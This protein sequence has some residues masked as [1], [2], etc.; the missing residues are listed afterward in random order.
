MKRLI[1]LM[2]AL[3]MVLLP[4]CS[5]N[6]PE[7]TVSEEQLWKDTMTALPKDKTYSILFIG[8]SY[9]YTNDMPNAYF[10][11]MAKDAGYQLEFDTVT[12][13]AHKLIEFANSKDEYGKIVHKL[14]SEPNQY[15][16][17]ILQEQSVLPAGENAALF[18]E[19]VR[20]LA[21]MVR[22]A[23]AEPILFATW[24]RKTGS[25]TLEKYGWDHETMAWRLAAAYHAIGE[26]LNIPVVHVGLGFLNINQN[27]Q[28]INLYNL[29]MT[30]PSRSGSYL[31]AACLFAGI[32][33]VDPVTI[34]FAGPLS[35]E[36]VTVLRT[37]ARS[38]VLMPPEIP[39]GFKTSSQS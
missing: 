25:E 19:G 8:N 1:S 38:A 35:E 3:L 18:Y 22:D 36:V 7:E 24:G 30:H 39:D 12:K 14:L 13:G 2:L 29:D 15:D 26:E 6:K 28:Q 16:Y 11:P 5:A 20:R 37:A 23:G 21:K 34:G 33:K 17:V 32:F 4:G 10:F 27:H 9:T 31:T